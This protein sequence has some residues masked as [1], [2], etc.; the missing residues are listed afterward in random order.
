MKNLRLRLILLILTLLLLGLACSTSALVPTAVPLPSA[1]PTW[2]LL[3]PASPTP[4]PT[5]TPAPTEG[6]TAAPG[7]ATTAPFACPGAPAPRVAVGDK[8]RVTFTNGLPLRVRDTPVVNNGNVI[9]Q[10]AEGTAFEIT[11]G[12][13]CAPIP[14]TSD[15]FVFWEIKVDSTGLVGWVAEG[16][17]TTYFVEKLP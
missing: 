9:A 8:A 2:T 15:S 7:T 13:R 12:P 4:A 6:P 17:K 5:D 14:N 16:D 1:T 11:D 3:P 10:I